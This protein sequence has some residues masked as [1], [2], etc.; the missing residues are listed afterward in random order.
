M[1]MGFASSPRA[2]NGA[3][4]A[5]TPERRRTLA[6]L[7]AAFVLLVAALAWFMQGP[8][9]NANA[10][11]SLVRAL[12]QGKPYVDET[13][14]EVGDLSTIDLSISNGHYYSQKAPGL[15]FV[16]VPVYVAAKALGMRTTG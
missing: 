8:S 16:T 4:M 13:R 9:E 3:R 1:R 12:A 10:H 5:A 6:W 11:Y 14:F 2:T 7:V 15:A